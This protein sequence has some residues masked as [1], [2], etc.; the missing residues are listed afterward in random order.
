[1]DAAKAAKD[2]LCQGR[3]GGVDYDVGIFD[4]TFDPPC[5]ISGNWE[6]LAYAIAIG[7]LKVSSDLRP[8]ES[9]E[10]VLYSKLGVPRDA[11]SED[12]RAGYYV[13]VRR[14]HPDKWVGSSAT[15]QK[16]AEEKFKEA[17]KAYELLTGTVGSRPGR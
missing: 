3:L 6:L 4:M 17:V 16:K 9:E 8:D 1:M 10:G 13:Q 5:Y 12:I 2:Q 15:E 11:S 7:V 14:W